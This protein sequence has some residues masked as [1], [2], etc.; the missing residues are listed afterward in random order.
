[1]PTNW[2]YWTGT[3]DISDARLIADLTIF[4][5]TQPQCANQA[6][7]VT[8]GDYFS[9]RYLWPRLAEYFGVS[10]SSDQSFSK[11]DLDPTKPYLELRLEEWA[12]DK[13]PV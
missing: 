6:F 4:A 10:A 3:D 13:R 9:W 2:N 1:M 7:N 11:K 8:N 12:K 5:S